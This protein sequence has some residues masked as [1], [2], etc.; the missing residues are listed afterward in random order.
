VHKN[1]LDTHVL[2]A[3][4]RDYRFYVLVYLPESL[5]QAIALNFNKTAMDIDNSVWLIVDQ[6]ET[7]FSGSRIYAQDNHRL[8]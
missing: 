4:S 2:R 1:L 6:S 7:G 8:S 3:I 5:G